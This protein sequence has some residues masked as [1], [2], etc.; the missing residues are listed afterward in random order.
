MV[1]YL[2]HCLSSVP[3]QGSE[4]ENSQ[5]THKH[6][7]HIQKSNRWIKGRWHSSL[8]PTSYTHY[9]QT[10]LALLDT[11]KM[12]CM[13]DLINRPSTTMF[14]WW[15]LSSL[16]FWVASIFLKFSWKIFW[17]SSCLSSR[18]TRA[19]LLSETKGWVPITHAV[20]TKYSYCLEI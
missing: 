2:S 6:Q 11:E 15:S 16:C 18:W 20:N 1:F 12:H 4:I 7:A 13:D 14:T 5:L 8:N 19:I 10:F 3:C 17:N 9:K